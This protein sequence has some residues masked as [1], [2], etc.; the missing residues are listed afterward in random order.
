[1]HFLRSLWFFAAMFDIHIVKEHITSTNNGKADMLSRNHITQF[2]CCNPQA[3]PLPTPLLLP[4][5]CIMSPQGPDW[6]LN[7]FSQCFTDTI[8]MVSPPATRNTYSSVQQSYLK[9][10]SAIQRSP[11]PANESTFLLFVTPCHLGLSHTTIMV[12]LS[13]ICSMHVATG[14]H[15]VFNQQLTPRL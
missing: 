8:T 5:L 2:F 10:S 6:T 7:S 1:M 14:Q 12:Y 15:I 11:T 4:L 13:A 9:F 3:T